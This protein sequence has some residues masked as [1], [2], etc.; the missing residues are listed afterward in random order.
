MRYAEHPVR[1]SL[2]SRIECVWTA[3]GEE[4]GPGPAER[5]LPDGCIEWIFHLAAPYARVGD[6]GRPS[7]QP[8]SFVVGQ[9]TRPLRIA[10]TG[11]VRTL[12]VRF[13]PGGA[14]E[15][16]GL[17]LDRLTN[18]AASP[19]ELWGAAGRRIQEEIGNAAEDGARRKAIEGFVESRLASSR[20]RDARLGAAVGV[21]LAGRGRRSVAEIARRAGW[22]PRQL[23]REFRSEVGLP[24]KTLSRII[25]FQNL[26]RLAGHSAGAPW[27]DLAARCGYSDQAHLVR[28]F[29]ELAGVTPASG[30][31]ACGELG[32]YFI[33][34]ARLDALLSPRAPG[35]VAFL[36][37][38]PRRPA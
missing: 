5:V 19:E 32:P 15:I 2:A 11:P 33:A 4:A 12:G 24:P 18:A 23:E 1:S 7:T 26:L 28:E 9:M 37:D 21:V 29:R 6:A 34:P 14:R 16:L 38:R 8:A 3:E 25:R 20:P 10:P 35:D 13:R 22:S 17:P 31:A 30:Q 36:Q 27:A